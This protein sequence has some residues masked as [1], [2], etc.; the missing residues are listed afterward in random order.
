M[1]TKIL[2]YCTNVSHDGFTKIVFETILSGDSIHSISDANDWV[3]DNISKHYDDF[4]LEF[5]LDWF[6]LL[7]EH[8]D[9]E[10]KETE[11]IKTVTGKLIF[12]DE[13][14][15]FY[16]ELG[17]IV[18]EKNEIKRE[19]KKLKKE[20]KDNKEK[21]NKKKTYPSVWI[22]PSGEVHEVGFAG[23][24]QFAS[25]WL[26]ENEPD[27]YENSSYYFYEDLQN[28]GWIRILGWNDPP[29]FVIIGRV[30]PKQRNALK[31]YCLSNDVPYHAFPEVLK[32]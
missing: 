31:S 20:V 3:D 27:I 4:D 24:N 1:N 17:K 18:H 30:T 7:F 15:Y 10:P 12:E 11:I 9:A 5:V 14:D 13:T 29:N 26:K 2:F 25:E 8:T 32:S 22:E 19:I 28:L 21:T 6:V 23:H 16:Y